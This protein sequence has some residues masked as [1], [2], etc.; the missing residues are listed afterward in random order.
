MSRNLE[1][2]KLNL[3]GKFRLSYKGDYENYKLEKP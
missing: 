1:Q 3:S 2:T